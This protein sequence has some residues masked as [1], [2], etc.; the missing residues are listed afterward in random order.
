V[1]VEE[2]GTLSVIHPNTFM[3]PT[4]WAVP[5]CANPRADPFPAPH[6]P[7]DPPGEQ[8]DGWLGTPVD[9]GKLNHN[10]PNLYAANPEP[11]TYTLTITLIITLITT[12]SCRAPVTESVLI[13]FG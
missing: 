4:I 12:R 3:M 13:L 2:A 10:D 9:T 6:D 7:Y 11:T 8:S 1:T 5:A